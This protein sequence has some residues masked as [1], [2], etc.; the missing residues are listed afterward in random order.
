MAVS[1]TIISILILILYIAVF[2]PLILPHIMS[3]FIDFI[4]NSA[5]MF[6]IQYCTSRVVYENNTYNQVVECTQQD[7]RPFIIFI[8]Q[9]IVY[10]AIP[11]VIVFRAFK[12]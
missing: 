12:K 1:R 4:N 6:N 10:F 3:M 9:L 7:L 5:D 2:I 11:L 8:F